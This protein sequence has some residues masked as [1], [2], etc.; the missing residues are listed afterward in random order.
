MADEDEFIPE[1]P[2]PLDGFELFDWEAADAL[3]AGWPP[4]AVYEA[5]DDLVVIR[6]MDNLGN[7]FDDAIVIDDVILDDLIA[8]L[9][10]IRDARSP[11]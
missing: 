11:K 9:Q 5:P 2:S 10:Q 3:C 4:I 8:K 6:Q 7:E 1:G